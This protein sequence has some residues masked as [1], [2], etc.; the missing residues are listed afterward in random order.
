MLNDPQADWPERTLVTHLGRWPKGASPGDFKYVQCSVRTP[1]WHLVSDAK[2]KAA[3]RSMPAWQLFDITQDLA[4]QRDVASAHPDVVRA[5]ND[6]YDA[7]WDSVQPQ[8]VNETAV[9]PEQN[10]FKVRYLKQ[11]GK[12]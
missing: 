11:F 6:F 7:W 1:R 4:E 3:G 10:P 9:G 12:P 5:L 2:R 8:L